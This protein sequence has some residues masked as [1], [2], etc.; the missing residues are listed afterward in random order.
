MGEGGVVLSAHRPARWSPTHEPVL[1][2][3]AKVVVW[4]GQWGRKLVE[5]RA[6]R[7]HTAVAD[8]RIDPAAIVGIVVKR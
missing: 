3:W 5:Q 8:A 4:K 1:P 7:T 6:M 2:P